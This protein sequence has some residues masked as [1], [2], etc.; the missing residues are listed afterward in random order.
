V[1]I[2]VSSGNSRARR[3][4]GPGLVAAGA[5]VTSLVTPSTAHAA[6]DTAAAA[7][8]HA[9][10]C[11]VN[12]PIN[13]P[14]SRSEAVARARSW[15]N[16]TPYNQKT[17]YT[18]QYGD[19]RTDCSGMVSMAWGLGG[20]GSYYWTGNFDDIST[21]IPAAALQPGDALLYSVGS[22]NDDHVALFAGWAD[23][24]HSQP[25][26]IQE[27]GWADNTIEGVPHNFDWHT[28]TPIRYNNIRG[29]GLH[30]VYGAAS[31]WVNGAIGSDVDQV[32]AVA[33]GS[34]SHPQVMTVENGTLHEVS[35]D[36]AGWHDA[37]T[38]VALSSGS[39]ISAV[40]MGGNWPTVMAV[41]N[42]HLFEITGTGTGWHKD[43]TTIAVTPGSSIS[44]VNSGG[45]WPTVMTTDQGRLY[46]I[47][48]SATT[49]WAK[50]NTG[51][52]A[53]KV[54]AIWRGGPWPISAT[55]AGGTLHEVYGDSAGW[56]DGNTAIPVEDISAVDMGRAHMD[57]MAAH[58]GI[59]YQI[60]ADA[61]GAW[62]AASTS[63][64]AS[65]VTSARTTGTWPTN[66]TTP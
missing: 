3:W 13:L 26:V 54:S 44:A 5:I 18:N 36:G 59:L 19:Y 14:M 28:Y 31:G 48:A 23:A 12:N 64:F 9:V 21:P 20:S 38:G 39:T 25:D 51:V 47:T 49:G 10:P 6:T 34:G 4:F 8:T 15:I 35:A 29:G 53:D 24:A 45:Q 27:T 57:V 60:T 43:D 22:S 66:I 52:R 62:H 56:H 32:S 42:G 37:D 61:S 55:I 65:T 58:A 16:K 33:F 7:A 1:D 46:E 63:T 50:A 17:C 30:E 11:A 2:P 40:N 41:D